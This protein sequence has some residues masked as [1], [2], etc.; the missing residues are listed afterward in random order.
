[1]KRTRS[2]ML[3][4]GTLELGEWPELNHSEIEARFLNLFAK[5]ISE[6]LCSKQW[7]AELEKERAAQVK[8]FQSLIW[9]QK[10]KSLG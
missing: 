7:P 4:Q 5:D 8:N 1:M 9:N 3:L 2:G 10:R 6:E